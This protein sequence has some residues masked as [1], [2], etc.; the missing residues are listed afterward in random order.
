[1]NRLELQLGNPRLRVQSAWQIREGE[2]AKIEE[3]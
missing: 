2:R 3:E 1:M